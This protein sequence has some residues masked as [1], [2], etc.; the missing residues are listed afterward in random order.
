MERKLLIR[1]LPFLGVF[2]LSSVLPILTSDAKADDYLSLFPEKITFIGEKDLFNKVIS[3][4]QTLNILGNENTTVTNVTLVAST[5]YCV[6]TSGSIPSDKFSYSENNFN[7]ESGSIEEVI[8]SLEISDQKDGIYEGYLFLFFDANRIEKIDVQLIL[9]E[10]SVLRQLLICSVIVTIII[11]FSLTFW[12]LF[13]HRWSKARNL[14]LSSIFGL[15]GIFLILLLSPFNDTVNLALIT[16]LFAP[17]IGYIISILNAK[18]DFQKKTNE[19]SYEYRNK[20][21]QEDSKIIREIIGE[22]SVHFAYLIADD[23]PK[24]AKIPDGIWNKSDKV[25]IVSDIHTSFLARYYRYIPL[26]NQSVEKLLE[27]CKNRKDFQD[28][29][30]K[31][32]EKLKKTFLEVETRLYLTLLYDIGLIQQ[33]FLETE[34]VSFPLHMSELL[35][36]QLIKFG[37][38]KNNQIIDRE[39][40]SKENASEFTIRMGIE[41]NEKLAEVEVSLFSFQDKL[42]KIE[43]E[44]QLPSFFND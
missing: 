44:T 38:M 34:L 14:M 24:P 21:G 26:Y 31:D 16:T 7:V 43:K 40:Y 11:V 9:I 32:F 39:V 33:T 1:L 36:A 35:K 42:K 29:L 27:L 41:I 10:N 17:L 3:L 6:N 12:I 15:I 2:I 13:F 20:M 25:G 8:I 19:L 28:K 18:R 5:L 23:W 4:E 22:L 37:I 30:E